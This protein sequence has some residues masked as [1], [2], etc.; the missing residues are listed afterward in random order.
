MATP[1]YKI[2]KGETQMIDLSQYTI[3][4]KTNGVNAGS[5][6]S[7]TGISSYAGTTAIGGAHPMKAGRIS[8]TLNGNIVILNE[9]QGN[10]EIEQFSITGKQILQAKNI[11]SIHRTATMD[12]AP[13][14]QGIYLIVVRNAKGMNSIQVRKK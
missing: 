9:L 1:N 12:I 7:G 3:A 11:E 6:S 8:L 4:S 13:Y 14:G 5:I 10:T 2:E